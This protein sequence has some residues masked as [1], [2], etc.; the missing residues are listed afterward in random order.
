MVG[1]SGAKGRNLQL[2]VQLL[3]GDRGRGQ[4]GEGPGR[5]AART[6]KLTWRDPQTYRHTAPEREVHMEE[7]AKTGPMEERK[8][9]R[10]I[11]SIRD[12]ARSHK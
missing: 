5:Q 1:G 3:K 9:K 10:D 12:G 7:K 4:E 6:Q 8:T 2:R 11:G